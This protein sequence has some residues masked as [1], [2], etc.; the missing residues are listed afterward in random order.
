MSLAKYK[1]PTTGEWL[2]LAMGVGATF[3]PRVSESGELSWSNDRGLT[4]PAPVII[5]GEPGEQGP[6][7]STGSQG[8]AGYTPQKGTDYW[9]AADK[10]EMVSDVLAALPTW[11]GGSY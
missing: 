9:T 10:S 3:V 7:G 4:N 2:P 5:K 6:T 11:E 8:P 1:D